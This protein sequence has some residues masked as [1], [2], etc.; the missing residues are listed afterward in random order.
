MSKRVPQVISRKVGE[1]Y[2][3]GQTKRISSLLECSYPCNKCILTW[4]F[5]NYPP[6][7]AHEAMQNYAKCIALLRTSISSLCLC[8]FNHITMGYC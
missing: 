1:I 8:A 6:R 3:R 5:P 7:G 4:L 2:A